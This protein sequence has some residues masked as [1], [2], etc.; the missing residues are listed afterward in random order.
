MVLRSV[1]VGLRWAYGD[2]LRVLINDGS[3]F[4]PVIWEFG[5]G[6]TPWVCQQHQHGSVITSYIAPVR[7]AGDKMHAPHIRSV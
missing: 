1:P 7:I 5:C 4:S 6:T 3:L 2:W